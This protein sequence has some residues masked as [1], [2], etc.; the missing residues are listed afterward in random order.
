MCW[1][2]QTCAGKWHWQKKY[3]LFQSI[4]A[5]SSAVVEGVGLDNIPSCF[6]VIQ[7]APAMLPAHTPGQMWLAWSQGDLWLWVLCIVTASGPWFA[8]GSGVAVVGL[9]VV[10]GAQ[11]SVL[12]LTDGK[13]G[14][15]VEEYPLHV[16]H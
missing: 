2:K 6:T 8:V 3:S 14:T 1:V 5:P 15:V 13:G 11:T 4:S 10:P 7:L 9:V 12:T 16:L